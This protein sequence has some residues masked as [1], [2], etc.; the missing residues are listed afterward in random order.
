MIQAQTSPP[1]IR[2]QSQ[3]LAATTRT[4]QVTCPIVDHLVNAMTSQAGANVARGC[5]LRPSV[6]EAR[7]T[8]LAKAAALHLLLAAALRPERIGMEGRTEVTPVIASHP[9]ANLATTWI[10]EQMGASLLI[11]MMAIVVDAIYET[12]V[13]I[14]GTIVDEIMR[15]PIDE[16]IRTVIAKLRMRMVTADVIIAKQ[17]AVT[18]DGMNLAETTMLV[19]AVLEM[20]SMMMS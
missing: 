16:T 19:K 14:R 6:A 3:T 13:V 4:S 15:K 9:S 11:E 7:D 5:P 1:P 17:M 2:A 20:V 8:H 12:I 18:A 10:V